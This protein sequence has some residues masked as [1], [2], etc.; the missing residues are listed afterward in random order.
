MIRRSFCSVV[1]AVTLAGC[2]TPP[3]PELETA[4]AEFDAL[5]SD[6]QVTD[7]VPL[8]VSEAEDALRAAQE[9][10]QLE[11][12]NHQA[13][14]AMVRI[15][16]ARTQSERR[17]AE[18]RAEA[19]ARRA[20]EIR[21]ESRGREADAARER[22]LQAE[23]RAELLRSQ[24]EAERRRA[25]Q[26]REHASQIKA[27]LAN[28]Q[29]ELAELKPRLSQRGLVLTLGEVLF[30]FDSARLKPYT[31]RIM[32]RLA[33]FLRQNQDYGLVIEGHTDSEGQAD[34]NR[35]LSRSRAQ[36]VAASLQQ[37]GIRSTRMR[38][39]GLGEIRPVASNDTDA[40]RRQNRRVEIIIQEP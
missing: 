2:A 38:V 25:E 7:N 4:E 39:D 12:R 34:Y 11:Q 31:E 29:A 1:L 21:L 33:D 40:G 22:A 30:D 28:A 36:S 8:A 10:S 37:Q 23:Q 13:R 5:R 20:E 27:E 19:A 26:A 35:E 24:A 15:Q 6:S 16:I 9:A 17:E 32:T 3:S 18:K 14:L